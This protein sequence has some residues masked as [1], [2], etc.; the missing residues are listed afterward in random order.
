MYVKINFIARTSC[1]SYSTSR[2]HEPKKKKIS[3]EFIGSK[4]KIDKLQFYN[5]W[6]NKVNNTNIEMKINITLEKLCKHKKVSVK[7]ALYLFL[8]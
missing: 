1:N 2:L 3:F 7:V 5:T 6:Y 8:K 4:G